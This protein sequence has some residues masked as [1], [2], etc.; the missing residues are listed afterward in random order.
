MKGDSELRMSKADLIEAV[1]NHIDEEIF[2]DGQKNTVVDVSFEKSG[3]ISTYSQNE[4]VIVKM[5]PADFE[6]G[7]V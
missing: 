3:G 4:I 1:Q 2:A 7:A 5:K 6:K